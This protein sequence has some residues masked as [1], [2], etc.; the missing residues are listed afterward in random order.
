MNKFRSPS[1]GAWNYPIFL[2]RRFHRPIYV[3]YE[4]I[5]NSDPH[6]NLGNQLQSGARTNVD[7]STWYRQIHVRPHCF[8]LAE[9][10]SCRLELAYFAG[11]I[12]K[13]RLACKNAVALAYY[14][15]CRLLVMGS[16]IHLTLKMTSAQVVETSVTNNSS[17]QN[18]PHPDDHKI[19]T[20]V[21]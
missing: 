8:I 17:F 11:K 19:R 3:K 9:A 21:D 6:G 20:T 15:S 10:C 5:S 2:S 4:F 14:G 18:Y 7:M 13:N 12:S 16:C 1:L